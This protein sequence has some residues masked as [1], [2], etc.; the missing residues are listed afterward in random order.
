MAIWRKKAGLKNL[1]TPSKIDRPDLWGIELGINGNLLSLLGLKP[2]QNTPTSPHDS[3]SL[4]MDDE[5]NN[6]QY[7]I[8]P[9]DTENSLIEDVLPE[10]L[11]NVETIHE[12][13]WRIIRCLLLT[14]QKVMLEQ[15]LIILLCTTKNDK[16]STYHINHFYDTCLSSCNN[17]FQKL[18]SAEITS[19]LNFF[20]NIKPSQLK[21]PKCT[22]K[23]EKS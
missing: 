6:L 20:S 14:E 8:V 9:G 7:D 3:M 5:T 2:F 21:L 11:N 19:I 18:T 1:K 22:G 4:D 17:I 15:I 12:P 13:E 10:G 23:A 16:W